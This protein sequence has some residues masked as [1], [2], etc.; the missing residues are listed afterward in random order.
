[1][2]ITDTELQWFKYAFECGQ[3]DAQQ[4]TNCEHKNMISTLFKH[5]ERYEQETGKTMDVL[6]FEF[7]YLSGAAD[8][9]RGYE[10]FEDY[11]KQWFG[12]DPQEES[13]AKALN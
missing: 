6:W 10:S 4:Q 9:L 8:S 12:N 5:A 13:N 11:A 3:K 2:K 7:F 1:M